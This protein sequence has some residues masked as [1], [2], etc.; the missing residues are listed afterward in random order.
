MQHT[1]L[2]INKTIALETRPKCTLYTKRDLIE[3]VRCLFYYGEKLGTWPPQKL[4]LCID[5][6]YLTILEY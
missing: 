6:Q 2:T 5:F 4:F 1:L 3:C